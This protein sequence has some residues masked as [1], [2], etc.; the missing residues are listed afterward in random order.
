MGENKKEEEERYLEG[1]LK[2]KKSGQIS[3]PDWRDN[4]TCLAILL[5]RTLNSKKEE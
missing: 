2:K 3:N 1:H 4:A 5:A